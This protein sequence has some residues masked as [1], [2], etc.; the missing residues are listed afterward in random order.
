LYNPQGI[1]V[2]RDELTGWFKGLDKYGHEGNRAFYLEAW[3]GN[4]AYTIDRIGRVTLHV[5]ALTIPY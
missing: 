2:Y 3:N 4:G 1:L 5:K